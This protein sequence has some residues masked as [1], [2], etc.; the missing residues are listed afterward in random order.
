M[1]TS[2]QPPRPMSVLPK[3]S[4]KII[5]ES[6]GIDSLSDEI[7]S[8]VAPDVEY[9]L[10]EIAQEAI[11]F[12]RHSKRST[13]TAQ[14]I[15]SALR[16][17]NVEA[18]YGFGVSSEPLKFV[19]ATG[20]ADLFFVEDKE[21]SFDKILEAPLPECPRETT[22]SSHWLAIEGVQPAINENPNPKGVSA[23]N[24]VR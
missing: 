4:I 16:L 20:T 3:E 21:L 22:F 19:K 11:K 5:A 7:A 8:A 13:L 23:L 18:L 1:G 24:L 12:M 15:N 2:P 14:D 9:R 10:R 17:R 6:V